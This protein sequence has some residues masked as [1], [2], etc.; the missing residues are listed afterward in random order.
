MEQEG[1]NSVIWATGYG[2]DFSWIKLPVLDE[3]AYPIQE[4]GLSEYPGLYFVGLV[5]LHNRNSALLS[6]VADDAAYIVDD[7][8]ARATAA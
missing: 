6:G 4:R 7:I 5:W 8:I 3:F 2:F 1:I